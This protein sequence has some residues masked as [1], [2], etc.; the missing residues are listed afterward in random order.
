MAGM[1]TLLD[2]YSPIEGTVRILEVAD[3]GDAVAR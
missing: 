3:P 2:S 1:L